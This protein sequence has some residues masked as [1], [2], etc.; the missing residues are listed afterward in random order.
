MRQ[1][2][3]AGERKDQIAEITLGIIV[4]EG[5]EKFTTAEIAKR[6]EISEGAIFRHFKT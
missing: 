2:K 4:Q 6:V 5:I 1:R 3:P